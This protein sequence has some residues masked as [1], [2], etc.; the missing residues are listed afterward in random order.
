MLFVALYLHFQ[1]NILIFVMGYARLAVVFYLLPALGERILSNLIIKNVVVSLVI[2]GLWPYLEPE[3]M[4]EQGWLVIM[5]KESVVGLILAMTLSVPFWIATV[6]GEILDNQRAATIS[7]SIDP[8]N[9]TQ[10]SI[11]SGFFSFAF[12]AIFFA[13][14]GMYLLMEALSQS[15][16]VFPRGDDLI[17]FNW[18]EAGRLLD[19]L[20][21]TSILL[22]APVLIVLMISEVMLGI[23]ARYCPQ[24][25]PFSL[26]LAVKSCVA[27]IIFLFYGFQALSDKSLKMFSL[28]SFQHFFF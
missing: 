18:Q 27:F 15:Y 2:M 8:V 9:G 16:V 5:V 1:N 11:L 10:S 3:T 24:L 20:M 4:S 26:S 21:Q 28:S 19:I 7:D 6:V 12:S 23:F 14:N 17:G 22:A 13:N 25:N